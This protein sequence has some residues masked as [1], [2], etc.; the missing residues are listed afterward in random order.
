MT[1]TF[2][3]LSVIGDSLNEEDRVVH[4]LANLPESYDMLVTALEASQDVPKWIL[5]TERL[6][7]E[8]NKMRKKQTGDAKSK[9]MTSKHHINKKGPKCFHCGKFGHL[10]RNCRQLGEDSKESVKR[11]YPKKKA[12]LTKKT[13]VEPSCS[14]NEHVGLFALNAL[15]TNNNEKSSWIVDSEATCHKC[16]DI[17][18]FINMKKLD[19]AEDITLGD[20]HS[21]KAFGTGTVDLNVR[22]SDEKQLRSKLFETLYVPKLSYNLLSVSK[23]TRSGKSFTFTV[24]LS[25]SG[26]KTECSSVQKLVTCTTWTVLMKREQPICLRGDTK[27]EIGH[28]H[29]GHLRM[30]NLQKLATDQLVN[31]LGYNVTKDIKFCEPCVAGKH[32]RY[33]FPKSGG[34][35]VTK[36]LEIVHSDV[37][38]RIEAKSL[39]GAEYFVTFM[40][41][42]S[43]YVWIYILKNKSEVFKK[44]LEWKSMVEK[45]SGKNIKTLCSDN[46]GEYTS[47]EFEDYF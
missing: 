43:R 27:E 6:L 2:D 9:A 46:G 10:K 24:M 45:S 17:D 21:V 1:E 42:K 23:A 20:G 4:L 3:E 25:S 32:Y 39:S 11:D 18:K 29:F 28:R 26:W 7:Y 13:K 8:E 40:D 31:G 47:E 33:S 22:V 38:G 5:V 12:F 35:R 44:F 41:D 34:K 37:W 19:K 16:H 14:K 15:T 30:K 36:L